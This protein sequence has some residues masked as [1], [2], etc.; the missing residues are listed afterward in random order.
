[1]KKLL[2]LLIFIPVLAGINNLTDGYRIPK[3]GGSTRIYAKDGSAQGACYTVQNNNTTNDLFVPTK[4]TT[5]WSSFI[6]APTPSYVVKTLCQPKSCKEIMTLMGNPADGVYTIDSDGAGAGTSYQTYCDMTT[7]GGGWTRIF[8]HNV[9]GGY[10]ATTAEAASKNTNDATNNLY[11]VLNKIPDFISNG[12]YHFR[13]TWPGYSQKNIWLQTTN[14]LDD[15]DVAGVTTI[16]ATAYAQTKI[17]SWGGLE[18]GN[19]THSPTNSDSSLVDG[20]IEHSN[21]WFA[22]GSDAPYGTPPGIPSD[23]SIFSGGV[24]ET[25]LWIK[26]DDTYTSYNSCKAILDAGA[27]IGSGIYTIDPGNIGSPIPVYCDMTSDGGGWTRIFYHTASGSLFVNNA[28]ALNSNQN[29]PLT[30]TKYSIL[31]RLSG[32]LRSGKYELKMDWPGSPQ[33]T[34]KNWWTQ[35]SDFTSQPVAGYVG[36]SIDSTSNFWGGLEY[37]SPGTTLADGS[38]GSGNWYYAIGSNVIWGTAPNE[39]I[40][41]SDQLFGSSYGVPKVELWVK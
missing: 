37:G 32:F 25:V 14:P 16:K 9:A 8:R 27:S 12:K 11:S 5:E 7:D 15:V 3:N 4:S 24:S 40:P 19:G 33:P 26:D 28:E 2:A 41:A 22:V 13:M 39:G 1:M 31:N 35:T 36:I 29:M 34:A 23:T 10:F 21:W 17:N 6:A 30:T 38:V 18:L 20:S